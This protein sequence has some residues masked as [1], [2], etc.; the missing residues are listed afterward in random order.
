MPR[1]LACCWFACTIW[2]TDWAH[3]PSASY[4]G[5]P[6][7]HQRV[8]SGDQAQPAA[9]CMACHDN[10][11]PPPYLLVQSLS[12]KQIVPTANMWPKSDDT[13]WRHLEFN[14]TVLQWLDQTCHGFTS[15]LDCHTKLRGHLATQGQDTFLRESPVANKPYEPGNET[16]M[17]R[18]KV[19]GSSS[20]VL[21]STQISIFSWSSRDQFAFWGPNIS[22]ISLRSLCVCVCVCVCV[23]TCVCVH[24]CVCACACVQMCACM[25][26]C[27]RVRACV[28][29]WEQWTHA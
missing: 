21:E 10:A 16:S 26:A 14:N 12:S 27:V 29:A 28:R 24:V 5:K 11:H 9:M 4:S 2:W 25:C 15:I 18:T 7:W 3:A 17:K 20:A 13:K 23:C 8:L 1:V 6:R 19:A 22:R